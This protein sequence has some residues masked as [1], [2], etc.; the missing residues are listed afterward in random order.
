MELLQLIFLFLEKMES[1]LENGRGMSL[2]IKGINLNLFLSE[3]GRKNVAL[4]YFT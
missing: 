3:N 1:K 4:F 2:R